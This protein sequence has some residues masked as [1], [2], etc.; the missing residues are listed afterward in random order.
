MRAEVTFLSR[1]VFGIDEDRV[2]RAR[3][4]TGF[5][6]DADRFVE[7]DNAVRA[8][9]HRGGGTGRR[10]RRV[11]ALIATRHLMRAPH[12]RPLAHVH[13]LDVGA[14]DTD[15][16]N[17]LGLARGRTRM[18]TDA[19]SVIDDFRPLHAIGASCLLVDHVC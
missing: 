11:G 2:V 17:I 9:E 18:T 5:A 6:A 10:T 1:M 8:L 14:R 16:D 4:H 15:G 3:G 7:I 13:V 12:L 19:T